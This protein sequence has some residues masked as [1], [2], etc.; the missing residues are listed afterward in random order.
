[1]SIERDEYNA[2][3]NEALEEIM[4]SGLNLDGWND[5]K[6]LAHLADCLNDLSRGVCFLGCYASLKAKAMKYRAAGHISEA[7]A[8][9]ADCDKVYSLLPKCLRW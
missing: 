1:M 7:A 2:K 6:D 4:G 5:T 9:E 8:C 3:A